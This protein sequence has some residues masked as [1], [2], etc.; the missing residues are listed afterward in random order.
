[1]DIYKKFS[2]TKYFRPVVIT[3]GILLILLIGWK[4]YSFYQDYKRKKLVA[5]K[6][7]S[8]AFVNI[9]NKEE[10]SGTRP[11]EIRASDK[12]GIKQVSYYIDNKRMRV[13]TTRPYCLTGDKARD[14]KATKSVVPGCQDWDS[15]SLP[16]GDH[17]ILAVVEDK[18]GAISRLRI[19]FTVKN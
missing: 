5:N 7:P 16:N 13:D 1:M 2:Q 4:A 3:L 18:L 14:P 12:N 8:A 10:I 9:K 15:K 6:R 17:Q 19:S 11:V